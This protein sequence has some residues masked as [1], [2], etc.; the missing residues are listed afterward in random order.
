MNT[1]NRTYCAKEGSP[2]FILSFNKVT[3]QYD[4]LDELLGPF[5]NKRQGPYRLY[6]FDPLKLK[7]VIWAPGSL[8]VHTQT[9]DYN[10]KNGTGDYL[11][12]R[13]QTVEDLEKLVEELMGNGVQAMKMEL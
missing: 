10:K 1:S 9:K 5:V 11:N 2:P 13:V 12:L 6:A 7:G 8:E 3:C 4:A